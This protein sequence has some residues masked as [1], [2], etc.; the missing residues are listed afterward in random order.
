MAD[1]KTSKSGEQTLSPVTKSAEEVPKSSARTKAESSQS[2]AK[3]SSTD[4]NRAHPMQG[5]SLNYVTGPGA[6]AYT[7]G[8]YASDK[9]N[10]EEHFN[11]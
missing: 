1:E 6:E 5:K 3:T 8:Q 7:E 9:V 10:E 2:T 11:R 4:E